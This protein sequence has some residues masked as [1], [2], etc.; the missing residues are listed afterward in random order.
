MSATMLAM[1]TAKLITIT[2]PRI[3]ARSFV[4]SPR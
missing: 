2:T 4:V 3:T 1:V